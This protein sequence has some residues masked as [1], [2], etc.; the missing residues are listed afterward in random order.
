MF[1]VTEEIVDSYLVSEEYE[2]YARKNDTNS[3][4]DELRKELLEKFGDEA[5]DEI[6]SSLFAAHNIGERIGIIQG[7]RIG[8]RL[9]HECL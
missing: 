5:E 8:L 3:S 6:S 7:I 9:I 1:D 2:D 4:V